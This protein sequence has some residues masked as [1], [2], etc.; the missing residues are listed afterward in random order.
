MVIFISNLGISERILSAFRFHDNHVKKYLDEEN[1]SHYLFTYDLMEYNFKEV[2]ESFNISFFSKK[3]YG[4]NDL[5]DSNELKQYESLDSISKDKIIVLIKKFKLRI[6]LVKNFKF[7]RD[8]IISDDCNFD[9][10]KLGHVDSLIKIAVIKDD[11]ENWLKSNNLNKYDFIFTIDKKYKDYLKQVNSN[12][13]VIDESSVYVELKN[14]LNLLF[15]RKNQKFYYFIKSYEKFFP[16]Y[17]DYFNILDSDYFDDKWYSEKYDLPKNTDSVVHFLLVGCKKEYDPSPKFSV[18]EYYECN[19]DVEING[20][21]PL[22]HYELYG[23]KENRIIHTS[24]IHQRNY[25]IIS[26]SFYFDNAWYKSTYDIPSDVDCVEH[27]LIDGFLKGYNP[28]PVF[29]TFEYYENNK[30]VRANGM[31][32]LLHYELYGKKENRKITFS[33]EQSKLHRDYIV[34]SPYF[35]CDWYRSAYDIPEDMDCAEH[36]LKIGYSKRLDPSL[37]FSTE[38]YYE[39]NKDVEEYGMNPLLHYE[40]F[41]RSEKR[42]IQKSSFKK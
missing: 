1:I 15:K 30:D 25:S 16:K 28:G 10:D 19:R 36:Y 41:G 42:N 40:K 7:S 11:L 29:S 3:T 26:D 8:I 39:N 2:Y 5:V 9:V 4:D 32:P 18:S 23:K 35:D 14:I 12:I 22:V 6:S 27:Y 20:W 37:G 17:N 33:D 38:G 34:N 31:N 24:E 13:F 21:N